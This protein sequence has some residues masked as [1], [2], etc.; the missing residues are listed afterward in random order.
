MKLDAKLKTAMDETRLLILGAQILMGFQLNGTFQDA[1]E[2][3]GKTSRAMHIAAFALIVGAVALL[4]APSMHHRIVEQ[5]QATPRIR[6]V[7]TRCAGWALLPL[8]ATL[9]TLV[10]PA[11]AR[12]VTTLVRLSRA[13]GLAQG[14]YLWLTNLAEPDY[15]ECDLCA[16][17]ADPVQGYRQLYC[18]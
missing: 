13:C 17:A 6:D 14:P 3:L 2:T 12:R 9:V 8:A 7:A 16:L 11:S 15:G 10:R 1:F 4:I 5:G 18:P